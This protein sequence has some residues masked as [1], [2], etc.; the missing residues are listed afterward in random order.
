MKALV[1]RAVFSVYRSLPPGMRYRLKAMTAING[2]AAG[3]LD[4]LK[5]MRDACGKKRLDRAMD[6]VTSLLEA[7]EIRSLKNWRCLEIGCG[8]VPAD[9]LCFYLL[10]AESV[11]ITDYNRI[12]QFDAL[13]RAVAAAEDEALAQLARRMVEPQIFAQRLDRLRRELSRGEG[14]LQGL[15]IEYRAPM[16]LTKESPGADFDLV[17]SV[18]V[19]EHIPPAQVPAILSTLADSLSED[20]RMLHDINL[21]DHLDQQGDPFAF[22][23]RDNSY[24]L[25]TETDTR[26]NR[27][28]ESEWRAF[29]DE[30]ANWDTTTACR[31]IRPDARPRPEDLLPEF[32]SMAEDD[33]F[34]GRI[35]AVTRRK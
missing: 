5:A 31:M 13:A 32:A 14:E 23:R 2:H 9:A 15:G 33:R 26:G 1:S 25:A 17:Y 7:A 16:D 12:L 8:Y 4:P 30:L 20:G 10:G 21:Q 24:D 27:I 22:L 6:R 19:M 34:T 35:V 11:L 18:C 3:A 29:F 28:R